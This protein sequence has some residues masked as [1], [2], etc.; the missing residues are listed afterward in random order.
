MVGQLIYYFDL[1]VSLVPAVTP[2]FDI[3]LYNF[4]CL[5]LVLTLYQKIGFG[6]CCE[7]SVNYK[8]KTN[9]VSR[10]PIILGHMEH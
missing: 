5:T 4:F 2:Y 6:L 7:S 1:N 8:V 10:G 9:G 3:S